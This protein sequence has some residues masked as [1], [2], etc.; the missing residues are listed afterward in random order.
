MSDLIQEVL[1]LIP[2]MICE[3]LII[4]GIVWFAARYYAEAIKDFNKK[5]LGFYPENSSFRSK[6]VL[7]PI[8]ERWNF[9][10]YLSYILTR[11]RHFPSPY[12]TSCP[13]RCRT[14]TIRRS[15]TLYEKIRIF[16]ADVRVKQ[17][18]KTGS[19][20]IESVFDLTNT[21]QESNDLDGLKSKS[22]KW[23]IKC[24]VHR[25]NNVSFSILCQ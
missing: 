17:F 12:C 3:N 1:W 15:D 6:S 5:F 16:F 10:S 8:C 14:F 25:A 11:D 24:P 21:W 23:P 4:D 18:K 9:Q 20:K 22:R 19:M 13:E 2:A 7:D